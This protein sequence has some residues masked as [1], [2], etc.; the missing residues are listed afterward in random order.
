MKNILSKLF[1]ISL[2]IVGSALADD[3]S[4]KNSLF[5]VLGIDNASVKLVSAE[6][7]APNYYLLTL[8]FQ[9]RPNNSCQENY[10]GLMSTGPN[11][12][13]VLYSSP[14]NARC[15]MYAR[16]RTVEHT[17]LM[18]IGADGATL[19]LNNALLNLTNTNGHVSLSQY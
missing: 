8:S 13:S 17:F 19:K 3:Q 14:F 6:D 11:S 15:K 1:F 18:N 4:A 5:Y 9:I 10:E 12:Y 16:S 2:L 7:F